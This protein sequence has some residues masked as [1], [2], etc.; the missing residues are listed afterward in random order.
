MSFL[1]I[2]ILLAATT[3]ACQGTIRDSELEAPP[4]ELPREDFEPIV[5]GLRTLTPAQYA[6]SVREVLSLG[7]D[8]TSIE[9][10]GQ[11]PSSIAAARGGFSPTSVETYE[12][13]ALD[14]AHHVFD[15]EELRDVFVGCQPSGVCTRTFLARVGRLAFRRALTEDELERYATLAESLAT[16][17]A[18]HRG[19]MYALSGL[20]QSPH[21]L[22]RV[23][24]GVPDAARVGRLAYTDHEMATRLAFLVWNQGPDDALLAAAEEGRLHRDEDLLAVVTTMLEDER[25]RT[26]LREFLADLLDASAIATLEKDLLVFPD[27]NEALAEAMHAQFLR[28]AESAVQDGYRNL[29][30]TRVT[31]VN[32][33]LA[34]FYGLEEGYGG[35]L[36]VLNLDDASPR[37]G[38]LTTPGYLA[39]H[40]YLGKTSPALRG[41]FVR[42]RLLC[43]DIPPPPADVDTTLPEPPGGELVT[44]RELVAIHL[45]DDTCASCHRL[46][47]PIGL[48]L[49]EFDAVGTYRATENGIDI[50]ASGELE[51][52]PFD[53]A[54]GLGEVVASHPDLLPC[55]MANL[56]AYGAANTIATNNPALQ[57]LLEE[58]DADNVQSAI[59]SLA[60]SEHFRYAFPGEEP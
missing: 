42:R 48:A 30:T 52:V 1:R 4:P 40:A 38:I 3:T 33:L 32:D 16:P 19:L 15:N 57:P 24:L 2:V 56:Y 12:T 8:D 22:Y 49:E 5:A 27:F 53:D 47:D 41:L 7:A 11:W 51:G 43:R 36:Q 28:T 25:A 60:M 9:A 34:P 54:A 31:Y 6:A 55:L 44:T 17:E 45:E 10:F 26:G 46:M 13:L 59:L 50:D 14:A 18:P 29:F 23:E 20:L 21:F 35:S 58:M 37:A 39:L